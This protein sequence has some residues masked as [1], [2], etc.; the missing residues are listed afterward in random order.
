MFSELTL[1]VNSKKKKR[2]SLA[3]LISRRVANAVTVCSFL[4]PREMLLRTRVLTYI[5]GI[6]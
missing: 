2:V 5:I 4:R 1:K 6:A 3:R